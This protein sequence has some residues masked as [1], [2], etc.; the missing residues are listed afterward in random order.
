M[1]NE[2]E[3]LSRIENIMKKNK[4]GL[5]ISD[6]ATKL[7]LNR[8][9]TSKYLSIL[10]AKG[11]VEM[12]KYGPAKV[13]FPCE[14]T[15]I[16]SLLNITSEGILVL[17]RKL[18]VKNVNETFILMFH[19]SKKEL[20]N[21]NLNKSQIPIFNNPKFQK[22]LFRALR[23]DESELEIKMESNSGTSY[24]QINF[25]PIS[26]D[27]GKPGVVLCIK[28]I[29]DRKKTEL[30]LSK[31][32][33]QYRVIIESIGDPIFVLDIDY[34]IIFYNKAMD[35]WLKDLGL[36]RIKLNRSLFEN[37]SFIKYK[38]KEIIGRYQDAIAN[39]KPIININHT[40]INENK[41]IVTETRKIPV[42]HNEKII[43]IITI[44]RDITDQ[45]KAEQKLKESEELFRTIT[46]QNDLGIGI[47]RKG[48]FSYCNKAF[49]N[50]TGFQV[51][52]ILNW[53]YEDLLEIIHPDDIPKIK[54]ISQEILLEKKI[55]EIKLSY[56]IITKQGDI[57]RIK[58]FSK[59]IKHA[60]G[61]S[62]LMSIVEITPIKEIDQKITEQQYEFEK[63]I[64]N[65]Q[66]NVLF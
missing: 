10:K 5:S 28:D 25:I 26:F 3:I 66:R 33:E 48:N 18:R 58:H 59:P 54:K 38:K 12:V 57:K 29:T 30:E 17:D 40:K 31:S 62:R 27:G 35:E 15:P 24:F 55:K 1:S 42:F 39:K 65:N 20:I 64:L 46:E 9:S 6:I 16:I 43:Q 23:G 51:E 11:R 50:I 41:S 34:N 45:Y 4:K 13:F 63:V 7:K 47:H 21:K 44:I 36:D 53:K 14:R 32:E 52:E 37:F 61:L 19:L 22:S 2:T 8:N 56:R 60:K 49:A